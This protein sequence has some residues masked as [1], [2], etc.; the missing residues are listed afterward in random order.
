MNYDK[1]SDM[2]VDAQHVASD[3]ILSPHNNEFSDVYARYMGLSP[4]LRAITREVLNTNMY[5]RQLLTRPMFNI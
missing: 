3:F 1:A 4:F 5:G 2:F